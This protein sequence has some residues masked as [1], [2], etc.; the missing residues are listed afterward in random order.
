[1]TNIIIL[2]VA[3]VTGVFAIGALDGFRH[4]APWWHNLFGGAVA[5]LVA[6]V[7]ERLFA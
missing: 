5:F 3:V 2:I 4:R 6:A 7:L 1:M